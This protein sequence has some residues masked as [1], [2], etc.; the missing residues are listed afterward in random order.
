MTSFIAVIMTILLSCRPIHHYWQINPNPGNVC[1][2]AISKPIIWVSF[3]LN[4]STDI[5]LFLIPI[6]MLW[7]S[8]LRLHKKI[9]A[10]SVLSAGLLVI[11]CA[12]LKSIYV[13]VVSYTAAI[14]IS[15]NASDRLCIRIPSWADK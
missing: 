5:S 8:S 7:K 4:I 3:V 12:T 2:P 10:T 15:S 14:V 6:P 13:I 1:Q 9:A 11:I